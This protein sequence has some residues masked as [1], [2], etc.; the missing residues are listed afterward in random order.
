VL[1]TNL[2]ARRLYERCGF[3]VEG[4]QPEQFYLGGGYVDDMLLALDLTRQ[5]TD[6]LA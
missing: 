2:V 3:V 1:G 4:V 5:T 6:Q